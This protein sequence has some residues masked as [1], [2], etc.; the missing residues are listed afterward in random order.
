[1]FYTYL[2][3]NVLGIDCQLVHFPGHEAAVVVLPS[4]INGTAYRYKGK[5]YYISDPTYI[6][7]STGMCMPD[8]QNT[9]PE[10]EE[11]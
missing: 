10:I 2:L 11:F 1:M 3:R 4:Q 5:V 7:A 6:G 9:A 8:F